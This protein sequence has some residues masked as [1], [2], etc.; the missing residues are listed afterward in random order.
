MHVHV[1][2]DAFLQARRRHDDLEG[3]TGRELRL[4]G[5]VQQRVIVIVDQLAP[6]IARDAHRKIVGIESR[7]AHHRQDLAVARIH[8]DDGAVLVPHGLFG[9]NL[10]IEVD[11]QLE[12]LAGLGRRLIQRPTSLPRLFTSARREPFLPIRIWLYCSSTPDF[13]TTSPGL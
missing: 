3:R 5:F 6:L 1:L 13:P 2:R 12:L 4:N 8:G 10:Q 7:T 9:G 11:G